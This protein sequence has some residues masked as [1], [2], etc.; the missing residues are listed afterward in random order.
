M[1]LIDGR[2][3]FTNELGGLDLISGQTAQAML[4]RKPVQ[5]AVLNIANTI[6]WALYY[7]G[8][9]DTKE[10]NFPAGEEQALSESLVAYK[11]GDLP[12][13]LARYPAARQP[14]SNSELIYLAA[15]L[16]SVGQ[17]NE[18]E[19]LLS[20]LE[21]NAAEGARLKQLAEAFR[22]VIAIV[23]GTVATLPN[24]PDSPTALLAESIMRQSQGRLGLALERAEKAVR[25]DPEFAFGWA[26]VAELEFGFGRIKAAKAALE[27]S[28]KLAA[29]NPEAFSLRGFLQAADGA[30]NLAIQDFDKSIALD[31]ALGNAWL[32]RGLCK[33]RTGRA[34][35][36]RQ[37]LQTAATLEPQ[38]SILRSYLAKAY[39]NENDLFHAQ[40]E[41]RLARNSDPLDPTA[42]LYSGLLLQQENRINESV[43]ALEKSTE[44]N[45]NRRTYR[46]RLLL[47]Q[48]RA[49]RGANLALGYQDVGMTD[50]AVQEAARS[51][52]S[53]PANYSAHLFLGNSFQQ[54]RDPGTVNL[55]Y[56]TP[57]VNEYLLASLLA[58]PSAGVLAQSVSQQEY[59]KLFERDGPGF[60]ST[61]E[62]LS[63]G[64]WLESGAQ[65]GSWGNFGYALSG[66]YLSQ[67]GWR[68]NNDLQQWETS[69]QFKHQLTP[70]D[71]FYFRAIKGEADGGD[72]L[73]RYDPNTA[74]RGLRVREYQ[75]PLLL[76]GYHHEWQPGVHTLVLGG[77]FNDD[78]RVFNPSNEVLLLQRF[79]SPQITDVLPVTFT[80]RYRD[81]VDLFTA[82]AQQIWQAEDYGFIAGARVQGGGFQVENQ[83]SDLAFPLPLD[84]PTNNVA[85][86]S[87]MERYSLYLYPQWRPFPSLL[88]VGGLSYDWLKYPANF[89][90]APLSGGESRKDKFS[91]KVGIVWSPGE[92][93][94]F[95]A[96]YT[97]SLGGVSFDQSFRLEP[98]QVAGFN[99]AFRSLIPESVAG[100]N[101]AAEFETWAVSWQE[102]ITKNTWLTL[103]AEWLNSKLGRELGVYNFDGFALTPGLTT[104][105]LRY[106]ERNLQVT[107]NQMIGDEW[108]L[109]AQYRLSH[110]RLASGFGEIPSTAAT[111]GGFSQSSTPQSLLHNVNLTLNYNHSSG[112][113]SQGQAVWY[114]QNNHGYLGTRPG[115]DFWQF[116]LV[117]GY[118]FWQRR[119]EVS[120][121]VLN[122]TGQDYRLNPLN[123]TAELPRSRTFLVAM[124]LNF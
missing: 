23:K 74:I 46:S 56:E 20:Q 47:D 78:Q 55:R 37:D 39:Q 91:P 60:A 9:L 26:R 115:D 7:P 113:F 98:T 11:N 71:S 77:W 90:F 13:A 16:L 6:Q 45:E 117:A 30:W 114:A 51:V 80:Q 81:R 21:A 103:S 89:R 3:Q 54:R 52:A 50:W 12:G 83:H 41:L 4:N 2:V 88:L 107:L 105:N 17:V 32:G 34:T 10:L 65:Y 35:E 49:M 62:Y 111:A 96:A 92:H 112:F 119:V 76:A 14:A 118:R 22:N 68:P 58:P 36:G 120:A 44:L 8:I 69:L 94:T 24:A 72:L 67:Q 38:R 86:K 31:G 97:R 110:S 73:Q 48:D 100:A 93:S 121:G 53:D 108:A 75:E 102:R 63:R 95:R 87:S 5:T 57:A 1:F 66:V 43:R 15:L 116:N 124:K 70:Q 99:Q 33:I 82:E 106:T 59:S 40:N 101:S 64:N 27:R 122:L 61:T 28:L 104:E 123:L 42:W 29:A 109:G 79:A 84:F 19:A 85:S 25:L 18:A